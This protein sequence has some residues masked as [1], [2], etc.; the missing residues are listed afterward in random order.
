MND[1]AR[2]ALMKSWPVD[3]V[4]VQQLCISERRT[5]R[6]FVGKDRKYIRLEQGPGNGRAHLTLKFNLLAEVD[7][8]FSALH[9]LD[10]FIA[11]LDELQRKTDDQ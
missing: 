1:W 7:Q 9:A 4:L 2:E 10:I 3:D 6:G 11:V 5:K 8:L